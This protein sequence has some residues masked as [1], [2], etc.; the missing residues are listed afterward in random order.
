MAE[1]ALKQQDMF[2]W[3]GTDKRCVK[4]KGQSRGNNP[5]LIKADLR[6]QVFATNDIPDIRR[7]FERYREAHS[8]VR[9]VPPVRETAA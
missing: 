1:K 9:I 6:K 4:V 2:H 7:A 5:S 3:T 8:G